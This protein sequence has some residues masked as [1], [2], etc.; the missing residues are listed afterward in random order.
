MAELRTH[1]ITLRGGRVFLRPMTEEDWEVLLR[2]NND[3]EIL[4]YAEGDD[5]GQYNID[6]VKMIYRSV[7][8]H[9]LCFVIELNGVPIGECWL[10]EMNL[11]RILRQYPG[12][13]CRRIDLMIGEKT[14]WG[15]GIGTE[16]I[17]LLV[18]FGFEH[19]K[20]EL[21]FACDV[22]AYNFRSVKAFQ[23]AGFDVCQTIP[24]PKTDKALYRYDLVCTREKSRESQESGNVFS[25]LVQPYPP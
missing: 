20:A 13:D 18:K 24:Q 8:Q 10:Q 7:S 19:A 6:E 1:S 4:Y 17:G 14:Y 9:A 12:K 3:S 16:V 23:N 21:I 15:Q 25:V 5:V 11:E 22:A 2:W